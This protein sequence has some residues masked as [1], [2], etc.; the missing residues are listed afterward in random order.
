MTKLL[1]VEER[2]LVETNYSNWCIYK[3][4]AEPAQE[5]AQN[6]FPFSLS[7]EEVFYETMRLVDDYRLKDLDELDFAKRLWGKLCLKYREL[8]GI[9]SN[10][11]KLCASLVTYSVMA[12][13]LASQRGQ[14]TNTLN[15]IGE[16]IAKAGH[17]NILTSLFSSTIRHNYH[18]PE[19]EKEWLEYFD[20]A[21]CVSGKLEQDFLALSQPSIQLPDKTASKN[22]KRVAIIR[23]AWKIAKTIQ[24]IKLNKTSLFYVY[25]IMAEE[26]WYPIGVYTQFL[27]DAKKAG[28]PDEFITDITVLS[29]NNH[30]LDQE[31]HYL[32]TV[33]KTTSTK[34]STQNSNKLLAEK[35]LMLT[36][37]YDF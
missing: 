3:L 15:V 23:E 9:E 2:K 10:N 17:F 14:T 31:E 27:L 20:S 30:K 16:T 28:V 22:E 12:L 11:S 33:D 1:S 7:P 35:T 32:D 6:C 8:E 4:L 13:I 5:I 21:D 18:D 24:E 19:A 29:R 25:R 37:F 34:A 26:G 36:H